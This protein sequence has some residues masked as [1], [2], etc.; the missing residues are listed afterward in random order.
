VS[1]SSCHFVFAFL[2]AGGGVDVLLSSLFAIFRAR[3]EE[4]PSPCRFIF[5]N[6][7]RRFFLVVSFRVFRHSEEVDLY[8][9]RQLPTGLFEPGEILL[10][11]SFHFSSMHR[12]SPVLVRF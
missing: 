7:A 8:S 9:L 6:P 3:E 10:T 12:E 11:G 4:L 2:T 1:T 5:V